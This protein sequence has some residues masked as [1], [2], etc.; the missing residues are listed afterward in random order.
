M[1]RYPV[2]RSHIDILLQEG[3]RSAVLAYLRVFRRFMSGTTPGQAP[4]EAPNFTS[5]DF[6]AATAMD[7]VNLSDSETDDV[8]VQPAMKEVIDVE[9]DNPG[10][11]RIK[12]E[13]N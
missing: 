8:H 11:Q 5:T 7:A 9:R 12:R 2:L 1:E 3:N 6:A 13:R 4:W 10:V